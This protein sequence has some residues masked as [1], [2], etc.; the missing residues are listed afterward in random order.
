MDF[1]RWSLKLLAGKEKPNLSMSMFQYYPSIFIF[2]DKI[3][4]LWEFRTKKII[5]ARARIFLKISIWTEYI[6]GKCFMFGIQTK[7]LIWQISKIWTNLLQRVLLQT[8]VSNMFL[9]Q[10]CIARENLFLG[11]QVDP[12]DH[13]STWQCL[14]YCKCNGAIM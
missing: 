6:D 12:S 8:A 10:G 11:K 4:K 5:L 1:Q 13:S 14:P 2:F 9:F 3:W 7:F